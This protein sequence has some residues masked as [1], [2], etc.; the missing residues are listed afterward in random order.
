VETADGESKAILTRPRDQIAAVRAL[1]KIARDGVVPKGSLVLQQNDKPSPLPPL[2]FPGLDFTRVKAA[3]PEGT[4]I[5]M[6]RPD[7]SED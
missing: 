1:Q 4:T 3:A 6:E 5:V 2:P 7:E